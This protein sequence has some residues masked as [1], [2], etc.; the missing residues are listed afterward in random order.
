MDIL[1]QNHREGFVALWITAVLRLP[2]TLCGIPLKRI[3]LKLSQPYDMD[4]DFAT[5]GIEKLKQL[6]Y[7]MRTD[8]HLVYVDDAV[9]SDVLSFVFSF[10]DKYTPVSNNNSGANAKNSDRE[11]FLNHVQNMCRAI[12]KNHRSRRRRSDCNST[13]A[14][15]TAIELLAAMMCDILTRDGSAKE[16]A[17][18]INP[19]LAASCALLRRYLMSSDLSTIP[20]LDRVGV[21]LGTQLHGSSSYPN[22]YYP[23]L[24]SLL[25]ENPF[26]HGKADVFTFNNMHVLEALEL[27]TENSSMYSSAATTPVPDDLSVDNLLHDAEVETDP[28]T[29][30]G[31]DPGSR[32]GIHGYGYGNGHGNGHG[33]GNGA[34]RANNNKQQTNTWQMDRGVCGDFIADCTAPIGELLYRVCR[35]AHQLDD[36]VRLSVLLRVAVSVGLHHRCDWTNDAVFELA[37]SLFDQAEYM[38]ALFFANQ[39]AMVPSSEWAPSN[40]LIIAASQAACGTHVRDCLPVAL[41]AITL[42]ECHGSSLNI[43]AKC[44]AKGLFCL[45]CLHLKNSDTAAAIE[46]L[47]KLFEN[48]VRILADGGCVANDPDLSLVIAR[49]TIALAELYLKNDDTAAAKTYANHAQVLLQQSSSQSHTLDALVVMVLARSSRIE[50]DID[51]ALKLIES[52]KTTQTVVLYEAA[53]IHH[54]VGNFRLSRRLLSRVKQA[55][56]ADD[57]KPDMFWPIPL[58]ERWPC[59]SK[60]LLV[61]ALKSAHECVIQQGPAVWQA[62]DDCQICPACQQEFGVFRRKHHCRSC[63]GVVCDACSLHREYLAKPSALCTEQSDPD[64]VDTCLLQRICD[65]CKKDFE[66]LHSSDELTFM[67]TVAL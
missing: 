22:T 65:P 40:A 63:G 3:I 59:I 46:T 30:S 57:F 67:N 42:L 27:N 66:S 19:N 28:D 15:S 54:E 26:A 37:S 11:L 12:T 50:G 32:S 18:A 53:I 48:H 1:H 34:V 10:N 16:P 20:S 38:H 31:T 64:D 61:I 47:V 60:R 29:E 51:Q 33:H 21:W 14:L 8:E 58:K 24:H 56:E 52:T 43:S 17:P 49:G 62:D 55:L 41:Q 35:H 25:L 45:A 4:R 36:D 9:T 6:Q 7:L 2:L 5:R 13:D 39:A 44:L 23:S